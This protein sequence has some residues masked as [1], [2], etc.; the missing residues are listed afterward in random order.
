M[1]FPDIAFDEHH[2][3]APSPIH[4]V[5]LAMYGRCLGNMEIVE[6]LMSVGAD[7]N[8]RDKG[9]SSNQKLTVRQLESN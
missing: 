7:A 3:A 4:P 9:P 6:L 2:P 1:R 5:T 8:V